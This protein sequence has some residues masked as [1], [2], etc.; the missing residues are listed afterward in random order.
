MTARR[1]FHRL[2]STLDT[3]FHDHTSKLE[4]KDMHGKNNAD[5]KQVRKP[6]QRCKWV[7]GQ[8]VNGSNGSLFL[9]GQV[10]HGS[11]AKNMMG[12]DGLK[13]TG[14]S[15]ASYKKEAQEHGASIL[16]PLQWVSKN[17][18]TPKTLKNG[19]DCFCNSRVFRRIGAPSTH[20]ILSHH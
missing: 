8:W 14:Q 1:C 4:M 13:L 20:V 2:F 10:D 12:Q 5:L 3:F 11:G 7:K 19:F 15:L 9:V 16:D 17:R 6:Y 18:K